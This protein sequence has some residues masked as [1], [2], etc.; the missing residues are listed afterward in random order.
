MEEMKHCASIDHIWNLE[1]RPEVPVHIIWPT[2]ILSNASNN[3][4][5]PR[6]DD[7]WAVSAV[8]T[9]LR[10][11]P[12]GGNTPFPFQCIFS[13]TLIWLVNWQPVGKSWHFA[14]PLPT[15]LHSFTSMP[16]D[17]CVHAVSCIVNSF[18]T[19]TS[20]ANVKRLQDVSVQALRNFNTLLQRSTKLHWLPIKQRI[21]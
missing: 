4:A 8:S 21:D 7:W 17:R 18:Q 6:S 14:A 10:R 15:F 1:I 9:W 2:F 20:V 5:E 12:L 16:F 19:H 13:K 11:L 3:R